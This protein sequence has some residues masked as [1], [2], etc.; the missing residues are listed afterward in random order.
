LLEVK[1]CRNISREIFRASFR[2][3]IRLWRDQAAI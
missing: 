3:F 1:L 2:V